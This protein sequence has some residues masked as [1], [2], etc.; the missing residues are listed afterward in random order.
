MWSNDFGEGVQQT[1]PEP[2]LPPS[3]ALNMFS[4][5]SGQS[6]EP[7]VAAAATS[8]QNPGGAAWQLQLLMGEVA[9]LAQRLSAVQL[10]V[11]AEHLATLAAAKHRGESGDGSMGAANESPSVVVALSYG[12]AEG[13]GEGASAERLADED[14]AGS[15]GSAAGGGSD[16]AGEVVGPPPFDEPLWPGGPLPEQHTFPQEG[17]C[18]IFSFS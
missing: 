1:P 8:A 11:A 2:S 12:G 10:D 14:D 17:R 6:T 7:T 3:D 4:P 16:A 15:V 5:S 13:A 18:S 9:A